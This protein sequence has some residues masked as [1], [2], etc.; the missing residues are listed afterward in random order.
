MLAHINEL[1]EEVILF[2]EFKVKN[3]LLKMFNNE[4]F[5]WR[6]AYLVEIFEALN[7]LNLMLQGKNGTLISNYDHLD[8]FISKLQL[9]N[10]KVSAG[11][12]IFFS[13]LYE[14]IKN[15]KLDEDLKAEIETH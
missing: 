14:A 11:N 6:L 10:H 3:D 12:I 5:H 4:K 15:Q 8:G 2:L 7:Q 1:K 9:W 13:R